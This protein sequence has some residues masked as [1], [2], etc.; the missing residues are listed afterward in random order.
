M[1][2]S[3]AY[4]EWRKAFAIDEGAWERLFR[5]MQAIEN[6]P[7][8]LTALRGVALWEKGILDSLTVLSVADE[9]TSALDIGSGGGFPGVVL[10]IARP[11]RS[12]T[13]VESR[14]KRARFLR[15]TIAMLKL[16][17]AAVIHQRAEAMVAPAMAHREQYDLVTLRAVGGF[18]LSVELGLPAARVGGSVILLRGAR[19][20]EECAEDKQWVESLG[21]RIDLMEAVRLPSFPDDRRYVVKIEKQ[22]ATPS[23]YPRMRHLGD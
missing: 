5:Y 11:D 3:E 18:R 19:A 23:P 14:E 20:D 12:V 16:S 10:A 17:G 8:N 9:W 1:R 2:W 13:L 21:G 22:E 15:D 4:P 6:A 7:L